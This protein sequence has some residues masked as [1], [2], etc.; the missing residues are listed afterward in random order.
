MLYLCLHEGKEALDGIVVAFHFI[1]ESVQIL[2]PVRQLHA[3]DLISVVDLTQL[4]LH[5]THI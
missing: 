3:N 2:L 1:G 4:L 5:R